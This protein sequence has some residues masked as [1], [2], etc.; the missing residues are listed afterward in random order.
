MKSDAL[1]TGIKQGQ[2]LK[3][4]FGNWLTLAN[5]LCDYK[6]KMEGHFFRVYK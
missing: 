4:L 5:S 1:H 2:M 6:W 3:S